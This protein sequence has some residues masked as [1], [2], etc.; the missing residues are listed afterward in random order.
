MQLLYQNVEDLTEL[1]D[2]PFEAVCMDLV[3]PVWSAI[4]N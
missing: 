3:L 4:K 1:L 2:E